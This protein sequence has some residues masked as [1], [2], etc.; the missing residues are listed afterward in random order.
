MRILTFD[1]QD[2]L[3]PPPG[4]GEVLVETIGSI[5]EFSG[6]DVMAVIE[7]VPR[8][9][10]EYDTVVRLNDDEANDLVQEVRLAVTALGED[11]VDVLMDYPDPEDRYAAV[12]ILHNRRPFIVILGKR[13]TMCPRTN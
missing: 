6:A 1:I 10:G 12:V 13:Q 7:V 5:M 4:A 11:L 3:Q 2:G 8:G 9:K